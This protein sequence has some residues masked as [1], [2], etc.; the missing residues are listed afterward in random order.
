MKELLLQYAQYNEWANKRITDA[1]YKLET[2]LEDKE[3]S[4]SFPSIRATVHH[5]WSAE[6]VWLQRL[7]LSQQ[8]I[9]IE[10]VFKGPF[11]EACREWLLVSAALI[12][13]IHDQ[14]DDKAF[15]HMLRF[16]DRSDIT[17]KMP[18]HQVLHQVFNHSTYHR[19]Q[20]VTM[21]RQVGVSNI[22]QMDFILFARKKG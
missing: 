14:R 3:I 4:S 13:F 1:M 10:S 16:A 7:L 19:G 11:E 15:T 20:L 5:S 2:R 9:W 8:P 22:P 17:Y 12:Q 21:L 6:F 18:L